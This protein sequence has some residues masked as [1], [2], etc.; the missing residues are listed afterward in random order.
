MDNDKLI[1]L[2]IHTYRRAIELQVRLKAE[3]VASEL[4][5]VRQGHGGPEPGVRVCIAEADLARALRIVETEADRELVAL[6]A[7]LA[8]MSPTLLIP[9]DFSDHSRLAV[10]VGFD[11]AE[12]LHLT[13]V[14]LH[15]Y[16]TPYFQGQMDTDPDTG[17]DSEIELDNVEMQMDLEQQAQIELNRLQGSIRRRILDGTLPKLNF[18][19]ELREGVPEEVILQYSRKTPPSFI[20]MATRGA[21]RRNR[22]LIGSVTAEVLDSCRVPMFIVPEHHTMPAISAINKVV[23][24]CN[25]DQQDILA[26]DTFQRMFSYPEDAEIFLV[27]VNPRVTALKSK[28]EAMEAYFAENYPTSKFKALPIGLGDDFRK[29]FEGALTEEGIQLLVVPNR[30]RNIFQRIFNPSVAH[31]I[32]FERDIPMLALPS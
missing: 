22:E 19:A 26:M 14:L 29:R 20:V 18:S 21:S 32:L 11:L 5:P 9:V 13:P 24:F 27:A 1:T 3:G 30:R 25:L 8:G 17:L 7:R 28:I 6:S 2:A 31:R 4:R 15:A 10:E 16:I 23:F 12:R